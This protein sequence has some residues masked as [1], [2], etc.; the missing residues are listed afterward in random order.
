MIKCEFFHKFLK[1]IKGQNLGMLSSKV[2]F[3]CIAVNALECF[4]EED[5]C[6]LKI[7]TSLKSSKVAS[8]VATVNS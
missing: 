5:V 8:S 1:A 7:W 2:H 4:Q 3:E 6:V